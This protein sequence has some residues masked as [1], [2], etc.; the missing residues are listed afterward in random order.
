MSRHAHILAL[1]MLTACFHDDEGCNP[2]EPTRELVTDVDTA[3]DPDP[4]D[5]PFDDDTDTDP[6]GPGAGA[7]RTEIEDCSR[8][9]PTPGRGSDPGLRGYYRFRNQ[10][11]ADTRVVHLRA[12]LWSYQH[13]EH[14][15][16]DEV[17][18][19]IGPGETIEIQ[20]VL[21]S[22][23]DDSV[24]DLVLDFNYGDCAQSE[25]PCWPPWPI[26]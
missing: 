26:L 25:A 19:N 5:D 6:G 4:T 10:C 24:H 8:T 23:R 11:R 21:Y 3:D 13:N 20:I 16:R 2:N 12:A 22:D 14:V 17:A 7:G 1:L 9:T 18:R 15:A